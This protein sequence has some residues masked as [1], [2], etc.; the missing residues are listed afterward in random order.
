MAFIVIEINASLLSIESLNDKC[1]NA[2]NGRDAINGCENLLNAIAGGV[3]PA[4]VKIVTKDVST[5]ISTSGTHS[6]SNTYNLS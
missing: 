5:T 2:T 3:A 6:V 4:S 1:Q